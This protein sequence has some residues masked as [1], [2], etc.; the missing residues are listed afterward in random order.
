MTAT[1]CRRVDSKGLTGAMCT[2]AAPY[3]TLLPY[4]HLHA[5]IS[6][7]HGLP[8]PLPRMVHVSLLHLGD[9]LQGCWDTV[10]GRRPQH[11]SAGS[12]ARAGMCTRHHL[13]S[14][15]LCLLLKSMLV[16]A[17][18]LMK[19]DPTFLSALLRPP[20]MSRPPAA[21]S[22]ACAKLVTSATLFISFPSTPR[23]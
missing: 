17:R 18:H 11:Q 22:A 10:I 12:L 9:C 16:L 15:R 5:R 14:D 23:S 3:S 13:L 1:R 8:L 2:T 6:A 4:K 20:K 21:R 19:N 7:R